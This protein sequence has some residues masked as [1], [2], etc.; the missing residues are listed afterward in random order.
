[1]LY[2]RSEQPVE[3]YFFERGSL[4]IYN[5]LPD[6]VI[7]NLMV[8][9]E[10]EA[11][12]VGKRNLE[13]RNDEQKVNLCFLDETTK[14]IERVT[15]ITQSL[16]ISGKNV[17]II[18]IT[19]MDRPSETILNTII[20]NVQIFWYKQLCFSVVDHISVPKHEILEQYKLPEIK[21]IYYLNTNKQLPFISQHD[22]IAKYYDMKVGDICK[23]TR[24]IS[25]VGDS[26][27]YRLV[28]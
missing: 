22:P 27:F 21:K 24:N 8:R 7:D 1:M 26:I 15:H 12:E 2:D 3:R 9:E 23:I 14:F 13:F 5:M 28:T 20:P 17:L 19:T 10:K 11:D 25:N 16:S 18:V 6:E 4:D